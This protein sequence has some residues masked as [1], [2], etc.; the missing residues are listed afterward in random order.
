MRTH[1]YLSELDDHRLH[2]LLDGMPY[3]D[4]CFLLEVLEKA[5]RRK[6]D[7]LEAIKQELLGALDEIDQALL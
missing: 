5:E 7:L 3:E 1:D 4:S 6:E 2:D